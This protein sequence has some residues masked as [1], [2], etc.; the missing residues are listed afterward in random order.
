MSEAMLEDRMIVL[1]SWRMSPASKS[2]VSRAMPSYFAATT[3]R[4][5]RRVSEEDSAA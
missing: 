5:G 1:I 4:V 2:S 3:T